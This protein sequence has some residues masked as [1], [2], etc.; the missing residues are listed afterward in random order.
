MSGEI[1]LTGRILPVGHLK[2]KIFA[3]RR[4]GIKTVIIPA[5]NKIALAELNKTSSEMW[6]SSL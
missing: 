1:T 3:A 4:A 5:K 2:E 6:L